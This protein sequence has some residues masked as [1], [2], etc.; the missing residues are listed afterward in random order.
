MASQLVEHFP[1]RVQKLFSCLKC[2]L[3]YLQKPFKTKFKIE[4]KRLFLLSKNK[5][6]IVGLFLPNNERLI[7]KTHLA[8]LVKYSLRESFFP[9]N[10]EVMPAHAN[11]VE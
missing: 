2:Q 6:F 4:T 3:I 1:N 8:T 7:D 9:A 11:Y 5:C 10:R